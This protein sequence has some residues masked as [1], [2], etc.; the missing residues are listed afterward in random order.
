MST[1]S[2]D[3]VQTLQLIEAKL[4]TAFATLQ[5]K[6]RWVPFLYA[7]TFFLLLTSVAIYVENS[8]YA[9]AILKGITLFLT[10]LL[11]VGIYSWQRNSRISD[12]FQD[13]YAG[14]AD[15]H[16]LPS[17]KYALDLSIS[18]TNKEL[19]LTDAAIR[20]N[21]NQLTATDIDRKLS[22]YINNLEIVKRFNWIL[23]GL[24]VSTLFLSSAIYIH[25]DAGG[26]MAAFWNNYKKPNPYTYRIMP[27]TV[28]LEQ[29]N[30][31]TPKIIFDGDQPEKISLNIRTELE[32]EYRKRNLQ[33]LND[34]TY[35][36]EPIDLNNNAL[37]FFSLD[38]YESDEFQVQVQLLPRFKQ[39]TVELNPPAY[40]GLP[41][42]SAS[43]PFS[44]LEAYPGTEITVEGTVNKML[45]SLIIHR[46]SGSQS[47]L[48]ESSA[49][50]TIQHTFGFDSADSVYFSMKD[51]YGLPNKNTFAFTLRA[52]ADESPIISIVQPDS[53]LSIAEPKE[54]TLNYEASDDFGLRSVTLHYEV[55]RAFTDE[56][57]PYNQ[58]IPVPG[59]Q[60]LGSY[61]WALSELELKPRDHVE[62]WLEAT[63]NDA[64]S[65]Y[66]TSRSR[67]LTI[68]VP[69]MTE[70]FDE[71][72]KQERSVQNELEQVSDS[73]EQLEKEYKRFK[74]QLKRNPEGQWEQSQTLDNIQDKRKNIDKKVDELNKKFD[75]MKKEL[76][77]N[78][79][80]DDETLKSYQELQKLMDQIKDPAIQEA[81]KKLQQSL[82]NMNQEQIRKAL[83]DIEFDEQSYKDR[84]KRTLE[85]FKKLKL[86]SDLGKM[87]K[88]LE[89][90][91]R[92]EEALQSDSLSTTEQAERQES[93]MDDLKQL[94]E[95][96][97]SLSNN[98][99]ENAQKA[100]EQLQEQ[101]KQ[102]ME[103]TG[104]QLEQ[105]IK[106]LKQQ[107]QSDPSIRK[108]QQQIQQQL[109][110]MA[111][112][113]QKAK[114]K[115]NQETIQV[116][117]AALQHIL[118]SLI[119]LSDTQEELSQRTSE[120]TNNSKAFVEQA[121]Q[122][123]NISRQFTQLSDSLYE[124]S[125]DIPQ[126]SNV[127]NRKRQTIN[128]QL[129][130]AVDQLAER[131]KSNSIQAERT[132]L[133]GIN[134]LSSMLVDLLSQMQGGGGQGG[135]NMSMQQMMK[136]MQKMSGQQQQLNQQIQQLINDMQGNRLTKDQMQRLDQL[137]KQQNQ[138]RKQL[139]QLQ[140]E[141]GLEPGDKLMSEL[142]RINEEMERTIN[143]IRGGSLDQTLKRR[144]QNILSRML[145]AEDAMQQ[146][147]K[148]KERK[149]RQ[150]EEQQERVSPDITLEELEQRIKK[151][152]K[153]PNQTRFSED[154]QRLIEQYFELLKEREKA[155]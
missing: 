128:D 16:N 74:D 72:D 95:Q 129:T 148:D 155:L 135:G 81:L 51:Q 103:Q 52:I 50:T 43:Y 40:T 75:Q 133:G 65:G 55:H 80:L 137:S 5:S 153:D 42:R 143:D 32:S 149:A 71:L 21:I 85:L 105:N 126:F 29:G 69:S 92:Q 115:M 110:Q 54:L 82:E 47:L 76:D 132:V 131:N 84:L 87:S 68:R 1:R 78:K 77:K 15:T 118:Y 100:I 2:T 38:Q 24:I 125:T 11:S 102:Q 6:H 97:D 124:V 91:S 18:E 70:Y 108:Q 37:Y 73:Y 83:E 89:K 67:R 146:R 127:I 41:T 152:L 66:K 121:R 63:D 119:N 99:P 48:N 44:R 46:N 13:F 144:Q 138:I 151:R 19:A 28:N 120:L 53:S 3:Y 56:P 58:S 45:D 114:Q 109:N 7:S 123:K 140:R 150:A 88:A 112:E 145:Q 116:N 64:V 93:I 104:E 57:N 60:E 9:S 142:E 20:S 25:P 139:Q 117:I 94:S 90:L 62:F 8:L 141:G 34:S 10:L 61:D 23:A 107:Q 98:P 17:L 12:T 136:K 147:G 154:Y 36:A 35:A 27:G 86:N 49:D 134:E 14:F 101:S 30:S 33:Q 4:R 59:D 79:I 122:Q 130:R 96:V 39:L 113:M 22:I 106:Q 111:K 31:F 26:R